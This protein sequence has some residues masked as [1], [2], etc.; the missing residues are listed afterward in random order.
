MTINKVKDKVSNK[1]IYI[2][3]ERSSLTASCTLRY[4]EL[5][6]RMGLRYWTIPLIQTMRME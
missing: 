2:S 3:Q 5:L 6:H 4:L 1:L